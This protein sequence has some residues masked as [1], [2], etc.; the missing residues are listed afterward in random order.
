[1]EEQNTNHVED[2][3]ETIEPL[4]A[5]AVQEPVV[6]EEAPEGKGQTELEALRQQVGILNDQLLRTLAEFDNYRKRSQREITQITQN[7]GEKMI[8][9]LLPVIDD[10]E[11]GIKAAREWQTEDKHIEQF[12]QG[13]EIISGKLMKV[14]QSKGLQAMESVGKLLDPNL[15]DALM[16]IVRTDVEPNTVIDEHEKGY[17]LND[18]VI[19]HAKVIVSKLPDS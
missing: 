19:R 9:E 10:M 8:T 6:S 12:I 18:K 15:H 2:M 11:R 16:Q 7:A 17:F 1:M 4:E 14:L 5:G 3:P 13:L